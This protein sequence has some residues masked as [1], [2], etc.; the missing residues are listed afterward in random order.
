MFAFCVD[1][2]HMSE[3][4]AAKRIRAGRAA[5]RFHLIFEM[6]ERGDLHLTGVHQLAKHLTEENYQEVLAR[7]KHK[8]MREIEHLIAEI[9]PRPDAPARIVTLPAKKRTRLTQRHDEG[10]TL[11]SDRQALRGVQ[12]AGAAIAA[13]QREI[14]PHC[15]PS[16]QDSG[17]G[18]AG[19]A[20]QAAATAGSARASAPRRRRRT[21]CRP[22][23]HGA[24][25][26][27]AQDE[28][29]ADWPAEEAQEDGSPRE[30][31]RRRQ[32]REEANS[33]NPSGG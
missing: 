30:V 6:V 14:T 13:R 5:C 1:R 21:D 12:N 31:T 20:R 11:A 18:R 17:H 7:A 16:L 33:G 4:I 24:S 2:F 10:D 9:A 22:S 19:D 28:G 32:A 25:S 29:R 3:A 26:E 15:A 23:A 27:D 8:T